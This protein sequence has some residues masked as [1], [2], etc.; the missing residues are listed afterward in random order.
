M[1]LIRLSNDQIIY[2]DPELQNDFIVWGEEGLQGF[3]EL[4]R[5]SWEQGEDVIIK[6]EKVIFRK[7]L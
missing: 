4:V 3:C 2:V 6:A 7:E 1:E 5:R